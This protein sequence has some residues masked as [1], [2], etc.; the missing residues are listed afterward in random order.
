[1][2]GSACRWRGVL[3]LLWRRFVLPSHRLEWTRSLSGR[4]GREGAPGLVGV[5]GLGEKWGEAGLE[6]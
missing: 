2:I 3:V 4:V 1:M 5:G 6:S